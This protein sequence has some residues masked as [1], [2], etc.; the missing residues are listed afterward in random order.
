MQKRTVAVFSI[1]MAARVWA[2]RSLSGLSGIP[3]EKLRRGKTDDEDWTKLFG[4]MQRMSDAKLWFDD[5]PGVTINEMRMRAR[6]LKAEQGDLAMIIVDYLQLIQ[7]AKTS[8]SQQRYVQVAEISKGLKR[9]ARELDTVV[10]A[11][12]MVGR[13]V[14]QRA[15]KRPTLSDLRES[16]DIEADADRVYFIYRDEVYAPDEQ[17]KGKA[18][19]IVSKNRNGPTGNIKLKWDKTMQLFSADT[20]RTMPVSSIQ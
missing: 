12:G 19:I 16:G 18:E 2:M 20:P 9:M 11:L 6:R 3:F 14:E 7:T 15:D 8:S 17:F 4:A 1:E 13:Q 5:D 10:V